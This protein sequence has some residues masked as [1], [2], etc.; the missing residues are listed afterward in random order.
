[1]PGTTAWHNG[2]AP[3]LPAPHHAGMPGPEILTT[4]EMAEAERLTMKAGVSGLA[5]MQRAGAG[6]A[7][8]CAIGVAPPAA[9]TVYC[10]PGNNGGDGL[11]A[12][13]LLRDAGYS[14]RVGLLGE[15]TALRG[16]AAAALRLWDAPT[17]AAAELPPP[18]AGIAID[19]LFGSGLRRDLEGAA[20]AIV[21]RLDVWR[22]TGGRLIAVD[23]PS[24]VDADTGQ[25]RGVAATAMATVTFFRPRPGHLLMPGRSLCGELHVVD[26]GIEENILDRLKPQRFVNRPDLWRE[27][28]PWPSAAGHKYTRGHVLVV[29]GG[30][31]S[32]GAARLA[33]RGAL[34]AGAGLVTLASPRAA[35]AANAPQLNAIMLSPCDS[36]DELAAILADPRFSAVVL[37]PGLG[38]GE[39]TREFVLAVLE[40]KCEGRSVILDADALTSFAGSRVTGLADAIK[41]ATPS[42]VV[43]PHEGEFSRLFNVLE[44]LPESV[45]QALES[46][47]Q[48]IRY[49]GLLAGPSKI[50]RASAAA[51]R[52]GATVVLKGA[53]TVV[54]APS[55]RCSVLPAASPWLASAGSG[56]VLAGMVGGLAV[57][58]MATFDAASAAVWMHAQAA[59]DFGP[60]LISEDIP[61][62][63]PGVWRGLQL[64][65][66]E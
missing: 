44:D 23:I 8:V 27:G 37:G 19:A 39:P 51:L 42:V 48:P 20:R 7:A 29:G 53:D 34:R 10:G 18:P 2:V 65:W 13:R 32:S 25:V 56:D 22:A 40:S 63:L 54:A 28:L 16:E 24:G 43:T 9:M 52:L 6:V 62:A 47:R 30:A 21:E 60:G 35:L 1:M 41:A 50:D 59:S 38:V 58:G 11:I 61:E 26:I 33:A 57:Q 3:T 15:P 14:V 66:A 12:A 46:D 5:L 45:S 64:P 36:A 4:V 17:E 55:G 31:W 49:A